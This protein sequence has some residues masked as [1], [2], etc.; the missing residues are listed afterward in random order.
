V[1]VLLVEDEPR[2]AS[3]VVK[4]LEADGYAV[5]HVATGAEALNRARADGPD[6]I[7]L[8]LA[9]PDVDGLNVLRRLRHGGTVVPV[10][11]LAARG[12]VDDRVQ[13]FDAGADDY[14][15]KP[16][17][18]EELR[19]RLRTRLRRTGPPDAGPGAA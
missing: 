10:I 6:V 9:L 18:F 4:G 16:F 15:T 3:F 13:G 12:D 8:D 5:E 11:V 1:K 2:I 7:V 19:A 17:A 14:L